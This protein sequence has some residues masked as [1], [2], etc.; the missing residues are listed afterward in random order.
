MRTARPE[1]LATIVDT[2]ARSLDTEG[3]LRW[4]FGEDRFEERIRHHFTHYDGENTRRG[5]IRMVADGAG[6]AV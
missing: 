2:A 3:M 1:D 6:I 5:W 4:S